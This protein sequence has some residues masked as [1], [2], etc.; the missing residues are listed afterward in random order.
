MQQ[1]YLAKAK[2]KVLEA[3][4]G[5]EP[6]YRGFADPGLTTW[7]PR[8]FK[9]QFQTEGVWKQVTLTNSSEKFK[10]SYSFYGSSYPFCHFYPLA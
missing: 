7:L 8:P 6:T 2:K 3:R 9:Y 5:I 10:G 1:A 4:V